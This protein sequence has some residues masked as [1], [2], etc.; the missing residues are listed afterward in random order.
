MGET[1]MTA[2]D[3]MELLNAEQ[4][5]F[6]AQKYDLFN[7]NCN[8]FANFCSE[9]LVGKQIPN[10]Y[11]NQAEEFKGTPIYN[12]LKGFQVNAN[13][14]NNNYNISYQGFQQ[15]NNQTSE[16]LYLKMF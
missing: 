10:S 13:S 4:D 3:F 5:N 11:L 2:E 12:M 16:S 9:M 6:T 8:H 15:S 1:E 7:N 14:N